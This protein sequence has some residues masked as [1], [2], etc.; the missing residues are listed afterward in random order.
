MPPKRFQGAIL[1]EGNVEKFLDRN[2]PLIPLIPLILAF[3][4]LAQLVCLLSCL[5]VYQ[6]S[7]LY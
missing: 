7:V 5:E 6:R 2:I 4:A 1:L 3:Q